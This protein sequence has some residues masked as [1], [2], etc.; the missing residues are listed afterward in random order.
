MLTTRD[1]YAEAA[2]GVVLQQVALKYFANDTEK[3]HASLFFNK[4]AGFRPAN[5]LKRDSDTGVFLLI[6][7]NF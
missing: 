4:A 3:T 5:L 7:R 2:T 1:E 6:L